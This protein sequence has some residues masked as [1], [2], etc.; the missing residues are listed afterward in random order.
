MKKVLT[1]TLVLLFI[2]SVMSGCHKTPDSPIVVGKNQNDMLSVAKQTNDFTVAEQVNAPKTYDADTSGAGGKLAITANDAPIALPNT[3]RFPIVRV[4]AA[5]FTQE[6]VDALLTAFFGNQTLYEV[7]YGAE[8]KDEIMQRILVYKQW[9]ASKEYAS[10]SDQRMIDDSIAALEAA[11]QNAPETNKNDAAVSDRQLKRMEI[12]DSQSGEHVAYCTGIDVTTNYEV[13][14]TQSAIFRVTNNNDMTE[15]IWHTNN[16]NGSNVVSG[17]GMLLSYGASLSY[18]NP[19]DTYGSNFD[20]PIPTS[21]KI[22]DKTVIETPEVLAKLKMTPAQAQKIVEQM[23]AAAGI[24]DVAIAGMYLM[25]DGSLGDAGVKAVP[26]KHYAY[27]FYLCRTVNG[28]PVSYNSGSSGMSAFNEASMGN[29]PDAIADAALSA[30]RW[31]YETINV[32]VDDTGILSF[33]WTSPL[34]IGETLVES[35]ALLPF[36]DIS[37]IFEKLMKIQ[38]EPRANDEYL[39]SFTIK[40]ERVSLEYQR[41]IEQDSNQSCLLVPV[42]NY[43]GTCTAI[44]ITGEE[45]RISSGGDNTYQFP[46]ASINAINGS[47]IDI[48]KGY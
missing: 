2:V 40:I 23:L 32:M 5:D 12:T 48:S 16:N 43:Y 46:L 29:S 19:G 42:W 13:D 27:K 47:I 30:Y 25:N 28:I 31:Y 4:T 11:Y 21:E 35:A 8:T 14:Y 45:Q 34:T 10:E 7:Q 9:K 22:S 36:V 44:D 1:V 6:Q 3:D 26:A 41:I 24:H 17:E 39:K 38:Y 33:D 37:A 18:F 15:A 20:P